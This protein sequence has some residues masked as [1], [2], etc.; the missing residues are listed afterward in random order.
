MIEGDQKAQE[1]QESKDVQ[2]QSLYQTLQDTMYMR[3]LQMEQGTWK[4]QEAALHYRELIKISAGFLYLGVEEEALNLLGIIPDSYYEKDQMQQLL[5]DPEYLALASYVAHYL[6]DNGLV[7]IPD[8]PSLAP[9]QP[10]A[11]A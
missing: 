1:A 6:E 7:E 11:K 5:S 4:D 10:A 8:Q 2:L 3:A 9:T